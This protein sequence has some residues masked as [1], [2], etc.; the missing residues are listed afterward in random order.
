M[1]L[2]CCPVDSQL[3]VLQLSQILSVTTAGKQSACSLGVSI[4]VGELSLEL[5]KHFLAMFRLPY[6][7]QWVAADH[8]AAAVLAGSDM[9]FF[10][11]KVAC[12]RTVASLPGQHFFNNLRTSHA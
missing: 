9:Y 1:G 12:D 11:L 3:S 8:I 10:N 2:H 5:L 6:S 7:F 4:K